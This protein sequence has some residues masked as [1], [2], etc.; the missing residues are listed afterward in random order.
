MFPNFCR[1]KHFYIFLCAF[2]SLSI[3]SVSTMNFSAPTVPSYNF[4]SCRQIM[5]VRFSAIRLSDILSMLNEHYL[6]VVIAGKGSVN[7]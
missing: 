5:F 4:V 3:V 6:T 2:F 1:P 7:N